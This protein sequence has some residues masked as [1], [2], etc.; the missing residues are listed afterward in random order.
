MSHGETG[1][2]S[3]PVKVHCCRA[4]G[5]RKIIP[6]VQVLDQGDN[7]DGCLQVVFYGDPQALIFKDR[8]YGQLRAWICGE[9]GYTELRVSN[10]EQ[11]YLKFL[12]TRE[13]G[14]V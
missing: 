6:N 2:V 11:L 13:Q 9:C 14:K 5:S 4:C 1:T 10:P 12:E 7:S 8:M 3:T